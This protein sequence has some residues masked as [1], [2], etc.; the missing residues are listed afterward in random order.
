[1]NSYVASCLARHEILVQGRDAED[2]FNR[3]H[4]RT[5]Q[6]VQVLEI[7]LE[8]TPTNVKTFIQELPDPT[9]G[10]AV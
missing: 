1:M 10:D 8:G 4:A 2:A 6:P 7:R 9:T 5:T 3:L